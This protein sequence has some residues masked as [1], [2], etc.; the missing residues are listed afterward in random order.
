M[1]WH[2]VGLGNPG[3]EYEKTRHN[4]GRMAVAQFAKHHKLGAWTF[5]KKAAAL[6]INASLNKQRLVLLLPETYMNNSGKA[7]RPFI[8]SANAAARLIV[9]HDDIDLPLGAFKIAFARGSAGHRGVQSLIRALHTKKFVRV[10]IGIAPRRKPEE[11]KLLDF[12][13]G[14]PHKP[15]EEVLKKTER[16]ISD[17]LLMIIKEGKERAMNEFNKT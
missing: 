6:R 2:V 17:A 11:K 14:R 4:A 13:M 15:E 7:V 12:L 8:G 1:T 9:C 16:K 3:E 5:D 10:R